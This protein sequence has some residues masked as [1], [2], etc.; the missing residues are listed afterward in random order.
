MADNMIGPS[1]PPN[2]TQHNSEDNA[3]DSDS[4]VFGPTLPPDYGSDAHEDTNEDNNCDTTEDKIIG[5]TLPPHLMQR[6]NV[7]VDDSDSDSDDMIGPILPT[8]HKYDKLNDKFGNSSQILAKIGTQQEIK[9]QREEWMTEM[10]KPSAPKIRTKCELVGN[11]GTT[12]PHFL[13]IDH[14]IQLL[15]LN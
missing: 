12:R 3:D 14:F 11:L 5:P 10:G 1:L 8:H 13:L 4:Q 2:W 7:T 15:E 6:H 9:R